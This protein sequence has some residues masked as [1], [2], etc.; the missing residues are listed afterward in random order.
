M[1]LAD[2]SI[3]EGKPRATILAPVTKLERGDA[4]ISGSHRTRP[5]SRIFDAEDARRLSRRRLP[6]LVYDFIEGAA[7]REVGACNNTAR[8]D[9]IKLQPRVMEDVAERSLATVFLG[10]SYD[11]PFGVAPM[12]MCNLS[13]AGA[14]E[15]LARLARQ[16]NLPLC[17][18]SAA[19]CTI[20]DMRR[21]AGDN[22]WFQ[23]YVA[24]SMDQSLDLVD[25]A[26][27]A[28][29]ETL[30]LTVDVPQVSRRTRDL[31]NGFS[32]PFRIGPRQLLDLALHP[33]WSLETLLRGVPAPRN[34]D[35][36]SDGAFDRHASRAGADWAFLD[37]LRQ[38]WKGRLI[39]KGVTSPADARRIRSAGADAVYVSN[40]GGRQLDSA[41]AAIDL[42]PPI[43]AAVGPEFPLLFDSGVRSGEDVLKA[44]AL[45]ADFVMLGRPLLHAVAAEGRVGL[46]ALID[47]IAG[48]ISVA[49][50]QV[51]VNRTDRIRSQC[52]WPERPGALDR[53][54]PK[55]TAKRT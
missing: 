14:D 25:R 22:A 11:L 10:Q 6:R 32:T 40:H 18:S 31:R 36:S 41:P 38:L 49:M 33:R 30:V 54:D 53:T 12:G 4:T 8:F 26:R 24:Q 35:T 45:G 39:V 51:G 29:Y 47:A 37:R 23:L 46:D 55:T 20:E 16:R 42:L 15:T 50:A 13:R 1:D 5:A 27:A 44:L 7:G 19:S 9:A 2:Y 3:G 21:W 52:L 48:D 34:F 17:L 43:R 28:G